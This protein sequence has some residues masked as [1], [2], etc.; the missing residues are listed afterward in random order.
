[1]LTTRN[2]QRN[3]T[4]RVKAKGRRVPRQRLKGPLLRTY[5]VSKMIKVTT[6][7]DGSAQAAAAGFCVLEARLGDPTDAGFSGGTGGLSTATTGIADMAAYALARVRSAIIEISGASLETGAVVGVN[8]IFSDTQPSTVITTYA[9]AKAAALTYLHTPL[10]KVAVSTG[11]S[12]FKYAPV[13]VTAREVIGDIMPETDRDFVTVVNPSHTAP[14]QEW[15][16]ALI[17]TSV[18]SGTNLT[19]GLD[20]NL[21]VTQNVEAFSRLI[22][23]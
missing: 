17:V 14:N 13:R 10:K 6:T 16:T 22:G 5:P 3:L 23:T 18:S 7:T 19:N 15:W 2:K 12:A 20:L 21:T 11:N 4:N 1:M 8:L 9:L